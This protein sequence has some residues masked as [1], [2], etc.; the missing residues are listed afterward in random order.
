M[1]I[2]LSCGLKKKSLKLTDYTT[3]KKFDK[4]Q[5]GRFYSMKL[6]EC[7]WSKE[8]SDFPNWPYVIFIV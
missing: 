4:I 5:A 1:V 6:V 8:I 2:E 7:A 3:L